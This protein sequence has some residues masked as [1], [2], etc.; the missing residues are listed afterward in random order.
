[1]YTFTYILTIIS[2]KKHVISVIEN[3]KSIYIKIYDDEY[4]KFYC[5]SSINCAEKELECYNEI[6]NNIYDYDSLKKTVNDCYYSGDY[7]YTIDL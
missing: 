5:N 2:K 7:M 6:L 4:K 1:M 3:L